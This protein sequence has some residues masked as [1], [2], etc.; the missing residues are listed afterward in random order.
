[1]GTL[2]LISVTCEIKSIVLVNLCLLNVNIAL[3]EMRS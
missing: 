2:K 1:M 3:L